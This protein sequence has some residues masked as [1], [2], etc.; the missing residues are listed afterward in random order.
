[1]LFE[2]SKNKII[3]LVKDGIKSFDV[4]CQTCIQPDWSKEGI[5]YLLLQKHCQCTQKSPVC[6]KDGWKLIFAG[7]RF[8]NNAESS[9]SPT[10]GEAL[11]LSWALK[12][13][14]IFSLGCP[15]LFVATNH[16]P[17][18]GIFNDRDLGSILNPWVQNL[19]EGTLPWR[20]SI[21]HCPGKW[22]QGPDALS[23]YPGRTLTALAIIREHPSDA[24]NNVSISTNE[25]V[26]V[27]GIYAVNEIGNV[28][29]N[30]IL[31]AARADAQYQDLLHIITIG[32]P[33]RRNETEPAHLQEFWEVRHRLSVFDGVALLDQRLV[34]PHSLRSVILNNLHSANQGVTG[35]R[36]CA[37]QC[38]YWPGLNSSIRNHRAT[39]HDCIRN[40]P[41]QPPEPLILT[42]S[43]T[44]PFE[45]I[46]AV[47]FHIGHFSHLT[48]VDR[49]SG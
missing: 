10:E 34:I 6:C 33:K 5:G 1:M 18:L 40:A 36:F 48:I 46:C 21:I 38:V 3:N 47:Y 17:L 30:H 37:N 2:S 22:T 43:P 28:T 11:A 12:H 26:Q 4:A 15:N 14:H 41:S 49:F 20:F 9:Y 8:T 44:Y 25:A 7:S 32:F 35:M 31:T 29:F 13:S 16:K 39:C 27:A 42:P 19:K 24:D 23:R 45:Q